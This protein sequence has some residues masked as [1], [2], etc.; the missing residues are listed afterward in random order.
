MPRYYF[1]I[2]DGRDF[3]D[4]NG[5]VLPNAEAARRSAVVAMGEAIKDYSQG[6]WGHPEWE[7]HVVDQGG[8]TVCRLRLSG[9]LL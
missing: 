2:R 3:P 5:T 9:D 8:E 1:N 7:M 4:E 6:F